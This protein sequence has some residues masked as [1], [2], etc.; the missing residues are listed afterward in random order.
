MNFR[1]G[2]FRFFLF[3]ECTIL[4]V[5]MPI[6]MIRFHSIRFESKVHPEDIVL[7]LLLNVYVDF[8]MQLIDHDEQ[9]SR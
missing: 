3:I 7:F 8:E 1:V 2:I 5:Q 4:L 6:E 9:T